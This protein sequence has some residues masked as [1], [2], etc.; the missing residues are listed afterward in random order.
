MIRLVALFLVFA[1]VIDTAPA[2]A[3]TRSESHASWLVD[4]R[5]VGVAI[6]VSNVEAQRIAVGGRDPGDAELAAYLARTVTARAAHRTCQMARAPRTIVA[7][8]GFRRVELAF[9]CPS[10]RDIILH[11]DAFFDLVP[12]HVTLAQ[13]LTPK[14]DLIEQLVTADSRDL[15]TDGEG[16]R[17]LADAGFGQFVRMGVLH[18]F[19][20]IDH[21]SFLVGLVLIARRLRD[22]AF[23]VTGFTLG[24]S[25]TLALAVTGTIRP[26]AEYI[27]ALVALTIA[28]I[29]IENIAVASRRSSIL[30]FV[31]AGGLLVMLALRL[32]GVGVLPPLLLLGA[33]LFAGN[34]L[35][36][37]GHLQDAGRLRLIV[38]LV[39]G[40]IHGFGFAAD[41]LQTPLPPARLAELLLG[42]NIGVELGQLSIVLLLWGGAAQL[43]RWR[44]TLPRALVVDVVA[45]V[46]VALGT[47]WFVGRSFA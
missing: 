44:L 24:H 11:S 28:L 41:L 8:P 23:V 5:A 10:A 37:S 46:L 32:A 35:I 6:S 38:T 22:L 40:L 17:G 47:F 7:A 18:I 12:S 9:A 20:G 21:I 13:V 29:G 14:G 2:S 31:T 30:A 36:V 16:G 45:A 43:A 27:D 19:T 3:H 39:F 1:A 33:A 26:H 25:L 4:G 42:F 15:A 34:Y